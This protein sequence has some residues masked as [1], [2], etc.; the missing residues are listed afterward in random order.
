MSQGGNE[1]AG[2]PHG[3]VGHGAG[4]LAAARGG[5]PLRRTARRLFRPLHE[6]LTANLAEE[7]PRFV[8]WLPVFF[9]LGIW[10]Y[11][12]VVSEPAPAAAVLPL[13]VGLALMVFARPGGL[14]RIA[15]AALVVAGL[16]FAAAKMRTAWVGAPVLD[17]SLRAVELTGVLERREP[18][19]KRGERLTLSLISMS[20]VE[21]ERLPARARIR[22]MAPAGDVAPGDVLKLTATVSPP[23]IPALP[24]GFDF[25]RSAYFERIGAVGYALKPPEKVTATVAPEPN[26]ALRLRASI[27][28]LRQTIGRRIEAALPGERGAMAAAL[29]TGERGGISQETTDAYRDSGLVHILSISGLHMVIMAGAVF[30]LLRFGLAAIPALALTQPIK[31]WAAAGGAIGAVL[32]FAIS[33]GSAATLRAA[34][35]MV[36]FFL[37]VILGR[38]AIAMRNVAIAALIILAIAPNNLLDVGFQMSFAAVAALVASYEAIRGRMDRNGVTPGPVM[39]GALFLGGILFSTLIAG[40]AVTPLSVYH[41]HAM[42]HYAPLAN[43][44]AVPVCNLVVM[45]AALATLVALP[46]GLEAAPLWIMGHGI[47][48]MGWVAREVAALPGAVTHIPEIP[49]LAFA[50]ALA[51]GLWLVLWQRRWRLA[52]IPLIAAGLAWAPAAAKPDILIGREGAILAVRDAQG[53][54]AAHAERPSTFELKRWLER[55]GDA[56][57]PKEL[58][59]SSSFRCDPSGCVT[60]AHGATIALSRNPASLA[61]DC[62]RA[63]I[64]IV[65]GERPVACNAPHIYDRQT[66]RRTGTVAM[67]RE[68]DG[69]YRIETV[70][71]ARGL[72]PWSTP[73]PPR[74]PRTRSEPQPAP[75]TPPRSPADLTTASKQ[76][77]FDAAVI[78]EPPEL[79][80]EIE[81]EGP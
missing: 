73:P 71:D 41:F 13:V 18:H 57:D 9:G 62:T 22:V 58:R 34:I 40:L 3:G 6:A 51:G 17:R 56:R 2:G 14:A 5:G 31:K 66:L 25:A 27:E 44:I 47:D 77:D 42:Q 30:A 20:D 79:R 54:L 80:P 26:L 53:R 69:T 15:A 50:L 39:R 68:P 78:D 46:F 64:L 67:T 24:G 32:D 63:K 45:P 70:A 52:G 16:G 72:R 23:S 65:N 75:G 8:N 55:D 60:E 36:V 1:A 11:F 76:P 81:D 48:A 38:P 4:A 28:D 59:K 33:G 49:T 61:D 29:I 12:A 10:C 19:A 37:A 35:M 7:R 21:P 43:L 74:Q